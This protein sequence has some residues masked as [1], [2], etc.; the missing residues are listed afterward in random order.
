MSSVAEI[1]KEVVQGNGGKPVDGLLETLND[2]LSKAGLAAPLKVVE[3]DRKTRIN[4]DCNNYGNLEATIQYHVDHG[5]GT[6]SDPWWTDW[7]CL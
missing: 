3:I 2:R 4:P 6:F 5:D 1:V 7:K